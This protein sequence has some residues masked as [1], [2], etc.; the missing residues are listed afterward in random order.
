MKLLLLVSISIISISAFAK[1]VYDPMEFFEATAS[2]HCYEVAKETG[3]IAQSEN[4]NDF[5]QKGLAPEPKHILIS[6][7]TYYGQDNKQYR[8]SG[9]YICKT[10]EVVVMMSFCK[11][12]SNASASCNTVRDIVSAPT[13]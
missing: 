4:Y 7:V 12:E 8:Y 13:R 11:I 10:G 2:T 1:V 3:V 5:L 9:S 6:E